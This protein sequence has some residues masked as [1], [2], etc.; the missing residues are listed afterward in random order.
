MKAWA[1]A[2]IILVIALQSACGIAPGMKM[3]EPAEVQ[4]GQVVRVT[5]ITLDL[6]NRM[7]AENETR[8]RQVAEEFGEKPQGYV[9]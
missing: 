1:K 7:E 9:I 3:T 2:G 8:I 4:D 5:P 6:L